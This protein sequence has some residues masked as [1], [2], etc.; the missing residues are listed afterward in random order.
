MNNSEPKKK[1]EFTDTKIAH[2][3]KKLRRIR[4]L[5]DIPRYNVHEGDLGGY[6]EREENLNQYDDSWVGQGAKVYEFAQVMGAACVS[7]NAEVRGHALV[8]DLAS[9]HGSAYV[10]GHAV[11]NDEATV[12]CDA[13]VFDNAQISGHAF[14]KGKAQVYGFAKVYGFAVIEGNAKVKEYAQVSGN[15]RVSGEAVITEAGTVAGAAHIYGYSVVAGHAEVRGTAFLEG[16]CQV[17]AH[18]TIDED[19]HLM[20]FA[21]VGGNATVGG[22]ARIIGNAHIGDG[23]IGSV[24]DYICVG[25]LGS[26]DSF[27]TYN[28]ISGTVCTGCFSGTI[29]MFR[30]AIIDKYGK[31][32]P[33]GVMYLQLADWLETLQKVREAGGVIV[34]KQ[35]EFLE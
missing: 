20:E 9:V 28:F 25:P 35:D 4:A 10:K 6:L 21:R 8:C 32:D 18:A 13:Q 30:C 15:A 5:R 22:K 24:N 27:T 33:R 7:E 23:R 2:G 19:A 1:Y 16:Q 31:Q 26:R 11:V 12:T 29:P 3:N 14:I 34:E 17:R